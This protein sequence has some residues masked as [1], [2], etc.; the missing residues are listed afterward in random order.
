[1]SA[2]AVEN[3]R[4]VAHGHPAEA[5]FLCGFS[6]RFHVNTH[7]NPARIWQEPRRNADCVYLRAFV[8]VQEPCPENSSQTGYKK[9]GPRKVMKVLSFAMA[10][11]PVVTR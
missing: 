6:F 8:W 2:G 3:K 7:R 11:E 1:M 5:G 4:L 9:G 10:E